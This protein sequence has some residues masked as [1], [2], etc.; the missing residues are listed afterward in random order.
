MDRGS[1]LDGYRLVAAD[2]SVRI[3]HSVPD[4]VG[5]H[6][7]VADGMGLAGQRIEMRVGGETF[8]EEAV[9]VAAGARLKH[10]GQLDRQAAGFDDGPDLSAHRDNVRVRTA[11]AAFRTGDRRFAEGLTDFSR[12]DPAVAIPERLA[13][14]EAHAVQHAV[15]G[16]PVMGGGIGRRERV[17][18]VA[19]V[20]AVQGGGDGAGDFQV[21]QCAL[22]L[23]G[24]VDAGQIGV[25]RLC[26]SVGAVEAR[27]PHE[28]F[29]DDASDG[30]FDW[31]GH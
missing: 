12:A 16:K 22:I 8:R 29:G 6:R 10:V 18:A 3:Q 17:R 28:A 26:L 1:A 24:R 25:W 9:K 21:G 5:L 13:A 20:E 27:D 2:L 14:F 15:A 7:I 11:E 19:Q 23:Q 30:G 4:H 31:A